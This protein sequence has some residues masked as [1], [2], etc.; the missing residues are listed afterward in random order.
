[1]IL[2]VTINPLLEKRLYFNSIKLNS[3]NRSFKQELKSG[4]KGINV[5]RQLNKL[6]INN[7]AITF[8]GGQAGKELRKILTEENINFYA[9]SCKSDTREATVTIDSSNNSVT[10]FFPPNSLITEKEAKDFADKLEKMIM[11]CSIVVFSGSSP[12]KETDFIFPYGIELANK[13]DKIS[14]L[15]TYGDH[16]ESCINSA[17]TVI[18]N[19]A[20]ELAQSLNLKFDTEADYINTLNYLYSKGI[21]LAFITNGKNPIYASKFNFHYKINPPDIN[22]VDPTGSG[23]AFVAGVVYGLEKDLVFDEFVKIGAALGAHNASVLETCNFDYQS[24]EPF[25]NKVNIETVGKKMK[26]IDDRPTI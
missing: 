8:L 21:K 5:S 10:T 9:V 3:N 6:N 24:F 20:N 1:M 13:Y 18:H 17:P 16:L 14:V 2:T 23:D 4:G 26:L 15:D 7:Q 19:N 12:C 25:I 11:N 22:E